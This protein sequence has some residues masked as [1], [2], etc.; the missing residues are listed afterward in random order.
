MEEISLGT[1]RK[2]IAIANSEKL[3]VMTISASCYL[4]LVDSYFDSNTK[5]F[6]DKKIKQ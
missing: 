2:E 6:I 1:S 3:I 5:K 4:D